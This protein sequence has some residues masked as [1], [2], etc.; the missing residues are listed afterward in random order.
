MAL[1]ILARTITSA[2]VKKSGDVKK[3]QKKVSAQKL[4]PGS[5]ESPRIK[6]SK[7]VSKSSSALTIRPRVSM[8]KVK[9]SK[10]ISTPKIGEEFDM[11]KLD[12]LL[13]SLIDNT[14]QL[15]KVTKKGLDDEKKRNKKKRNVSQRLKRQSR[16]DRIESKAVKPQVVKAP[17]K[18]PKS[19]D[20]FKDILG[21]G[22]RLILATGIMSL[23]NYLTDTE[24]RDGIFKF[25]EDNI[26]KIIIGAIGLTAASVLLPLT[27]LF[28]AVLGLGKILL[29]PLTLALGFVGE[30]ARRGAGAAVRGLRG[31]GQQSQQPRVP[32]GI[33]AG[34]QTNVSGAGR[35][36][37]TDPRGN[38]INTSGRNYRSN[39]GRV[40]RPGQTP[41]GITQ[42]VRPSRIAGIKSGFETGTNFG[43]RASGLQRSLYRLP[44]QVQRVSGAALKYGR[45][46]FS[47]TKGLMARVPYFG[48]ILEGVMTYFEDA[49]G[50]GQPDKKL[51][52]ALFTSGGTALGGLLGSFIPIP[53]L[54]TLVGSILGKYFGELMYELI[55]GGGVA[56]VVER[57]KRDA[58]KTLNAGKFI[59]NFGKELAEYIIK[60]KP[61]RPMGRSASKRRMEKEQ[62]LE[63]SEPERTEISPSTTS[64][65]V[66]GLTDIVP[67]ENLQDIDVGTGKVG[68]TSKR[69]MRNGRHHGGIDIG[70]SGQKGWY[71]SLMMNGVVSDVGTFSGYGETVV[72]TAGDKDYLFAHLALGKILVKKGEPYNGTPIGEIGDTGV[73]SG[74]HLHFEVSPAGT[75]GYGQD[76]DPMPYVKYLKIGKLSSEPTPQEVQQASLSPM[77][78]P[79]VTGIDQRASYEQS[80]TEAFIVEVDKP[81]PIPSVGDSGGGSMPSLSSPG[82]EEVNR[83]WQE[84]FLS[85]QY[86]QS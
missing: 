50:D 57:M 53:L 85:G 31:R 77:D 54:G 38:Q 19:P 45:Q 47:T 40:V 60:Y 86:N 28:G 11:N 49:D 12:D 83:V 80:G 51:D 17:F 37:R 41:Q 22:G 14:Q 79:T 48:S 36:S 44:G 46:L 76:E 64:G 81:M 32:A 84:R 58:I 70:T 8:V 21:M 10:I 3:D 72:I 68:L 63:I 20:F 13:S 67:L 65:V 69:G 18:L 78:S 73:G 62:L 66:G 9:P 59:M 6:S 52:K 5:S 75:G 27:P 15:K 23:L 30:V 56:A 2:L 16:E 1:P 7:Y 4:L 35:Y 61:K 71:V 42:P 29:A 74:E 43:G 55:R 34:S 39:L 26:G 82:M 25:L 33:G 24:R